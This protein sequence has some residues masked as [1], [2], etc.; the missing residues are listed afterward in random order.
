MWETGSFGTNYQTKDGIVLLRESSPNGP[1]NHYVGNL[2]SFDDLSEAAKPHVA[3]FYK[4]QGKL[5]DLQTELERAWMAYQTAPKTFSAFVVSQE[6]SPA[7]S[8][9]QV[10]Y[11]RTDLTQTISGNTVQETT[12]CAAFDRETGANI[13]L[14]DLF[15]CPE[16]DIAKK[17]LDLAEKDGS[18]PSDPAVKAEMETAFQMKYLFF[19]QDS[20]WL[21]F[22]QGTL[23]SQENTHVVSVS[24][25]DAC[26]ALLHPWAVPTT[27]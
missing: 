15:V 18:G 4:K 17:L 9:E 3:E 13:P 22:P 25:N 23:P 19:S 2:E 12:L 26:K 20:L 1:E 10:F 21:A 8:N 14:V 5:Y 7:A 24:F 27:T 6:T 16:K 11:F